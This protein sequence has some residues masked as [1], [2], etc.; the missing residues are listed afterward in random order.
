MKRNSTGNIYEEI[1]GQF[2]PDHNK[3]IRD[4]VNKNEQD[5]DQRPH[6]DNA[7]NRRKSY[8]DLVVTS[9]SKDRERPEKP[10]EERETLCRPK[11]N[12][13]NILLQQATPKSGQSQIL[14]RAKATPAKQMVSS[15]KKDPQSEPK[16]FLENL[17]SYL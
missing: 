17:G 8:A 4:L 12:A 2:N 16:S 14:L 13:E 3:Y 6:L 11:Y 15:F 9:H 7:H 1:M 10:R 5:E